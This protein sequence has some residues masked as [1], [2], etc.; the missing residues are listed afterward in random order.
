MPKEIN[1]HQLG[2]NCYLAGI[3]PINLVDFLL[4]RDRCLTSKQ[5]VA[6]A[7]AW[8]A[9]AFKKL[10]NNVPDLLQYFLDERKQSNA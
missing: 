10:N 2:L 4:E 7:T 6:V 8:E 1:Y 3:T 9:C 5:F